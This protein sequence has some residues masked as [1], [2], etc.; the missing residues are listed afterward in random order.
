M[1]KD[2]IKLVEFN[3]NSKFFGRY[4][5][6][7][8]STPAKY[9]FRINHE[10]HMVYMNVVNGSSSPTIWNVIQFLFLDR[11]VQ[12]ELIW[13][14]AKFERK[15]TLCY[16]IRRGVSGCKDLD[17]FYSRGY[18]GDGWIFNHYKNRK[19]VL[20]LH[21]SCF[22]K[23]NEQNNLEIFSGDLLD[24]L[25]IFIE[26]VFE[27]SEAMEDYGN[28]FFSWS[29]F[30]ENPSRY[31]RKMFLRTFKYKKFIKPKE[32]IEFIYNFGRFCDYNTSIEYELKEI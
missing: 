28:G 15:N 32:K 19:T 2:V 5:G 1:R 9:L 3:R 10:N 11:D 7:N 29:N 12:K 14:M 30:F 6:E 26:K 27:L 25:N 31:A 23:I 22:N 21:L 18:C 8:L 20:S 13:A 16:S 24:I 4:A 17:V